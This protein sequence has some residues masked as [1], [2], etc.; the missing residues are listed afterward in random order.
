MG[1]RITK[2]LFICLMMLIIAHQAYSQENLAF[3]QVKA[4][5]VIVPKVVGMQQA[6]AEA[7]LKKVGLVLAR[8]IERQT[9]WPDGVVVRQ[10]PKPNDKVAQGSSVILVVSKKGAKA[11]TRDL[12]DEPTAVQTSEK[13]TRPGKTPGAVGVTG[14]QLPSFDG[15]QFSDVFIELRELGFKEIKPQNV[16]SRDAKGTILGFQV[17]GEPGE[18]EISYPFTAAI[19]VLIS[20]GVVPGGLQQPDAN[21]VID[22]EPMIMTGL[23]VGSQSITTEPILMTGKRAQS[24]TFITD[25]IQMTGKGIQSQTITTQPMQMTGIRAQSLTITTDPIKMTGKRVQS[26]T[27]AAQPI[28][29]TG[30]R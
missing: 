7:A 21:M 20:N 15:K 27:I 1:V 9:K 5:E 24:L 4:K 13:S 2:H 6:D 23:R 28:Q 16:R 26:Q 19:T 25:P 8:V 17:G 29:M 14:A 3:P 18:T 22:T 30:K 10:Q 11:G 12:I